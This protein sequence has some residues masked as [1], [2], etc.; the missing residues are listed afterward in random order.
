[1][2]APLDNTNSLRHGTR[3][4]RMGMA[5]AT[6][7]RKYRSGYVRAVTLRKEIE[8]A[9]AERGVPQTVLVIA[10]VQTALRLHIGCEMLEAELR[11]QEGL[12]IG[13]V[14]SA[15]TMISQWSIMRDKAIAELLGDGRGETDAWAVL[16]H[17]RA[18]Q[19]SEAPTHDGI[20]GD[21]TPFATEPQE[22]QS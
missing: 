7:N 1:M 6:M 9:L 13:E 4:R 11:R 18:A 20:P 12:T 10:K 2:G 5:L 8:A 14:Q 19:T 15:R 16:D 17:A 21:T 22:G 3:S